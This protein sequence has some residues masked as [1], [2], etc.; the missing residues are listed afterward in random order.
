MEIEGKIIGVLPLKKGTS[1][2][3]GNE[4]ECQ[5]YVIET[6]DSH[7]HKC[8]FRIFGKDK[9]ARFAINLDEELIVSFEVDAHE[10]HGRWFN[11]IEAWNVKRKND[12]QSYLKEQKSNDDSMDDLPF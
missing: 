5:E 7:P 6:I 4:W 3:T 11:S 12:S 8:C 2:R 10:Y 1:K 9:I